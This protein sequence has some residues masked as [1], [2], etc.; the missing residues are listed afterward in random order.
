MN[1]KRRLTVVAGV[2]ALTATAALGS[3]ASTALAIAGSAA[4]GP[5]VTTP[6]PTST[7]GTVTWAVYRETATLDPIKAFDYPDNAAVAL[8]CDALV[9]PEP[10]LDAQQRHRDDD[11]PEPAHD[12]FH[13][14][15]GCEF[16]DGHPVTSQ[17]VVFS[18][19]RAADP[20]AGGFYSSVFDR[21]KS[22]SRRAR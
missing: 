22:I 11:E 16:W 18:L 1:G 2:L 10:G 3:G 9:A 19:E 17:D 5:V 8:S 15:L 21:V 14:A 20:N 7:A 4:A 12:R 13:A 6:A